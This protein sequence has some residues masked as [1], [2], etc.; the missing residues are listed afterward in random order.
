MLSAAKHPCVSDSGCFA[1][2]SMTAKVAR[3]ACRCFAALSMTIGVA[4]RKFALRLARLIGE[5]HSS[6]PG[7]FC[8]E[9]VQYLQAI[10]VFEETFSTANNHRM[11]Q[12]NQ[13]IH[14][15]LFQQRVDEG[16]TSGS[17]D[18]LSWLLLQLGD[19]LDEVSLHQRRVLPL[20]DIIQG[21]REDVFGCGVN[22]AGKGFISS[23]GPVGS[24]LLIGHAPQQNG[25]LGV[26]L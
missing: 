6:S 15:A 19:F 13:F 3:E 4:K 22:K 5:H 11:N 10:S 7:R 23:S 12:E 8:R 9:Q 17:T 14:Q 20:F 16:W 24:P 18:V 21:S 26:Q 25:V 1:A 2:L